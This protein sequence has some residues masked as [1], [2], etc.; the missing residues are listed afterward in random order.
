MITFITRLMQ[1]SNVKQR[2]LL[3]LCIS[4]EIIELIIKKVHDC[5]VY[6]FAPVCAYVCVCVC[7]CALV[8]T[9]IWEHFCV[10]KCISADTRG[11]GTSPVVRPMPINVLSI[12]KHIYI[13]NVIFLICPHTVVKMKVCV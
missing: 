2:K 13:V 5:S 7:V 9:D 10:F 4:S 12:F 1:S 3:L 11:V 6:A 8:W